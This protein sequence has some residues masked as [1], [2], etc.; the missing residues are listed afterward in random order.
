[1]RSAPANDANHE[2]R[3]RRWFGNDLSTRGRY[4]EQHQP[5]N[6]DRAMTRNIIWNGTT[7]EALALLHALLKHC[8]C[9]VQDGRTV[10]ACAGHLMLAHDQ[11]AVDG[12]LFMRRMAPRLLSEEFDLSDAWRPH[13]S[14]VTANE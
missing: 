12:L 5:V 4:R 2:Q 6:G 10:S 14:H 8:E 9:R 11:R 13:P 3:R 7:D 1:V